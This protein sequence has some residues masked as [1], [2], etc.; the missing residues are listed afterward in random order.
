APLASKAECKWVSPSSEK[1]TLPLS[2]SA[3]RPPAK[4]H[5]K[6]RPGSCSFKTLRIT[7][8]ALRW[9]MPVRTVRIFRSGSEWRLKKRASSFT[10]KQTITKCDELI[11]EQPARAQNLC[12]QALPS[13]D[14]LQPFFPNLVQ[15][16]CR[17]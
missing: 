13:F 7:F 1:M 4:P 17:L 16:H 9:P 15:Q 8:S 11:G 2:N 14:S 5:V 3:L 12:H 6:T 10:A